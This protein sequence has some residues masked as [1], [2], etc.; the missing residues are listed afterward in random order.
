MP[1]WVTN[2]LTVNKK[3]LFFILDKNDK[4]DFNLSLRMPDSLNVVSGGSNDI[5]IYLFLSDKLNIDVSVIKKDKTAIALIKNMFSQDWITEISHRAKDLWDKSS[6]EERTK[7][8]EDGKTL[9]DNYQKYGVTTWYDWCIKYWGTKWN[10]SDSH[11]EDIDDEKVMITFDT[12]WS[13]PAG[14]LWSLY[15]RNITFHLEWIEEQGYHGEYVYDG[16]NAPTANE[17]EFIEW[18]EADEDEDDEETND[19]STTK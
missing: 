13:A 3:D 2:N 6:Q 17:L 9:V 1:N 18:E 4:V 12:A 7:H 15:E 19:K 16:I 14:W 10:A 8:Y 5:D 11:V